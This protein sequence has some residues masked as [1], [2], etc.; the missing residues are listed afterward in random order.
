MTVLFS[1]ER[2]KEKPGSSIMVEE[3]DKVEKVDDYQ[4][5]ILLK[6]PSSAMLYNLAHP[7]TSIV[8]KKICRSRK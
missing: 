4:I 5:K 8:N 1:F 6:N 2:M 7:I 3:I